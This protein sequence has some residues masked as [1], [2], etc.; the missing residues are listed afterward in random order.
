VDLPDPIAPVSK[1]V[2]PTKQSCQLTKQTIGHARVVAVSFEDVAE[3][4][5][6]LPEVVEGT[7]YGAPA[8]RVGGKVVAR[9]HENDPDLFVLKVGPLERDALTG[10]H[11]HRFSRTDHRPER[12]DAV[13]M[14]LSTTDRADLDEVAELLDT[15]WHHVT[16]R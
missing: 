11:P 3:L 6:A 16:E 2:R 14:R 12:E 10:M 1:I 8:F 7:W 5:R 15:A 13:L 4:A 9:Q